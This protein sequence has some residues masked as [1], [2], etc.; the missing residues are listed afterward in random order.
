MSSTSGVYY[1]TVPRY[2]DSSKFSVISSAHATSDMTTQVGT[3]SVRCSSRRIR[4]CIY[5]CDGYRCLDTCTLRYNLN[6]QGTAQVVAGDSRLILGQNP[7]LINMS[8]A[9]FIIRAQHLKYLWDIYM[10]LDSQ[11]LLVFPGSLS[12]F[13]GSLNLKCA[14][15][16]YAYI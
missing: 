16:L 1:S 8:I 13:Q 7:K 11:D 4:C 12:F 2:Y 15:Y 3:I 9:G 10:S 6:L 5:I 14:I